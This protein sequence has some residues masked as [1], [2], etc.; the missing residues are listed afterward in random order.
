MPETNEK[1]KKVTDEVAWEESEA[2]KK[3]ISFVKGFKKSYHDSSQFKEYKKRCEKTR[4]LVDQ[5]WKEGEQK[6]KYG[7]KLGSTRAAHDNI[8]DSTEDVLDVDE[9]LR[10][11][12]KIKGEEMQNV[13]N[14]LEDFGN[15]MLDSINYGAIVQDR[16]SFIPI[17]GWSVSFSEFVYN[18]GYSMKPQADTQEANGISWTREH[19]TI[20]SEPKPRVIHPYNWFGELNKRV[21][22]QNMQGFTMRWYARDFVQAKAKKDGEGR[23]L[24]NIKALDFCLKLLKKGKNEKDDDHFNGEADSFGLESGEIHKEDQMPFI[25]VTLFMGPLS[26]VEGFYHD[27]NTYI[28]VCTQKMLLRKKEHPIDG[29]TPFNHIQPFPRNRGPVPRTPLDVVI[30]HGRINDMMINLGLENTIDGM[31]RR[32]I[33]NERSFL[34]PEAFKNPKGLNVILYAASGDF[35]EPRL[36]DNKNTS[37]RG[38][39]ESFRQIMDWDAQRSGVGR[40]DME[41]GMQGKTAKKTATE[42]QAIFSQINKR[43]RAMIKRIM[44]RSIVPEMKYLIILAMQHYSPEQMSFLNR[45]GEDR[46][47]DANM[48]G[49]FLKNLAIRVNDSITRNREL[50]AVNYMEFFTLAFKVLPLLQQPE[51]AIKALRRLAREKNIKGVDDF[52]PEPEIPQALPQG[53]QPMGPD[54]MPIQQPQWKGT[55]VERSQ[56][57][58]TGLPTEEIPR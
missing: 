5:E 27:S 50:D 18:E 49:I 11:R 7:M 57:I 2:D 35:F 1:K 32:W 30:P 19:D 55:P 29:Y 15:N 24:Y 44:K 31:I 54:G 40:T 45:D 16:L 21:F 26:G 17:Y 3:I 9:W 20:L 22:D 52:I 23:P 4:S 14:D 10:L 47:I 46:T 13:A 39:F 12:P 43:T 33:F 56:M 42:A 53:G 34:N 28:I 36:L 38:D 51:Y 48:A 41:A 6:T 37:L 58:N 25:D 8:I